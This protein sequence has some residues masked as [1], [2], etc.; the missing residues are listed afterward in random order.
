MITNKYMY[1]ILCCLFPII[2]FVKSNGNLTNKEKYKN[3]KKYLSSIKESCGNVCD[4]SLV[5]DGNTKCSAP[6]EKTIDCTT[7][8]KNSDIDSSSEFDYPPHKIPKWMVPE[9]DY[10][11]RVPIFYHYRDDSRKDDDSKSKNIKL[12]EDRFGNIHW[13]ANLIKWIET[14]IR[15]K[16]FEGAS[17]IV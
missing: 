12:L 6:I 14:Q 11:G 1:S 3:L 2:I 4:Q 17:Y 15:S 9:Y 7:L 13:G 10:G 8:F 16:T 5:C